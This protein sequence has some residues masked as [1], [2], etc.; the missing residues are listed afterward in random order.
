MQT[1]GHDF[2][3]SRATQIIS[4]W[5]VEGDCVLLERLVISGVEGY[6]I[7]EREAFTVVR[8]SLIF[9]FVDARRFAYSVAFTVVKPNLRHFQKTMKGLTADVIDLTDD[10]DS[11]AG[12]SN[13]PVIIIS[14][15]DESQHDHD[16]V[17]GSISTKIVGVKYYRGNIGEWCFLFANRTT[18]TTR[19]PSE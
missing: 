13:H 10:S 8:V 18:H 3:R 4:I 2:G 7:F 16:E 1:V 11:E 17:L 12:P 6:V 5:M 9:L 15:D 14:D 19:T